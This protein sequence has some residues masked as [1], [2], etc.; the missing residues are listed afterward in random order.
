MK[1]LYNKK[2]AASLVLVIQQSFIRCYW[3]GQVLRQ[4]GMCKGSGQFRADKCKPCNGLGCLCPTHEG[5]WEA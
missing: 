4:C 3:C 1:N 2:P 5:D